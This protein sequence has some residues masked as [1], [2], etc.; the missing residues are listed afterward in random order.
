MKPKSHFTD[1]VLAS[2]H[3]DKMLGIRAGSDRSPRHRYL[4]CR[5]RRT[6]LC[7]LLHNETG[8]LVAYVP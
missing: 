3:K 8:Q 1:E 2:V 7:P 6:R 4:G 5:C